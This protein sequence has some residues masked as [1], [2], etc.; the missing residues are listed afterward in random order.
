MTKDAEHGKALKDILVTFFT[1]LGQSIWPQPL[2]QK[3]MFPSAHGLRVYCVYL[4]SVYCV[5]ENVAEA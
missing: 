1:L 4:G 3:G 2:S 5:G